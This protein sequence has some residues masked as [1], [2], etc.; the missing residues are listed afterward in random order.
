MK[1]E[2]I[3]FDVSWSVLFKIAF[4][5]GSIA[6]LYVIRDILAIF[7][8]VIIIAAALS[9]IVDRWSKTIP[10]ILALISLIIIIIGCLMLI[11]WMIFPPLINQIS[12]MGQNFNKNIP[13][14]ISTLPSSERVLDVLSSQLDKIGTSLSSGIFKTT[15][16]VINGFIAFVTIMVLV[17]YILVDKDTMKS[18][19]LEYLPVQKKNEIIETLEKLVHKMG[20]WVRGQLSLMLIVGLIDGVALGVLGVPYALTLGLWAGLTEVIPYL[21][22]FLGLIPALLIAFAYSET[23]LIPILVIVIYALVQQLEANFLVPKV[24]EKAVGLSPIIIIFAILVGGKL[25]GVTGVI[26]AVPAA[27]AI[28]VIIKEWPKL[29]W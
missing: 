10:R 18:F 16:S 25:M 8:F 29:K 7:F 12:D 3:T 19:L 5:I 1:Q 2:K 9:P 26:L 6:F 14:T 22:P 17:F 15:T 21:G 27:A 11:S 28:S 24:M 23:L 13:E 4:L 20:S